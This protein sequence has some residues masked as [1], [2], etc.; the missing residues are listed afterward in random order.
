MPRLMLCAPTSSQ[1]LVRHSVRV[2]LTAP[3]RL[4]QLLISPL[5]PPSCRFYPSCSEYAIVAIRTHG[6]LRGSWLALTRLGRCHPF[7][8]G[9][10]DLVPGA[11]HAAER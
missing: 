9:G 11:A 1:R 5:L 8:P 6:V 7:H 3:I 10:V 4:Y 2:L